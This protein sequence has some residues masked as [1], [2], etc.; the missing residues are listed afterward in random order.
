MMEIKRF[1]NS[2]Y[3]SNT[4]V[5]TVGGSAW[6]VDIGDIQPVADWL[7]QH[8]L[9]LK[10]VFLT[11]AHYDHIY[12]LNDLVKMY[13]DIGVY[14][15]SNGEKGLYSDK[16][17]MSR[18]AGTSFVYQYGNIEVL[19]NSEKVS[20]CDGYILT[21]YETPGHDWSCMCFLCDKYLFTGD[22]YLPQYDVFTGFPKSNK[23]EAQQSLRFIR[24]LL[25][26]RVNVC[27]PGHGEIVSSTVK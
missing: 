1:E 23:N 18:Y 8:K 6:L 3:Q 20:L 17:N 26:D 13:P 5:L 10:G 4:Y 19:K 7:R 27:C 12:G 9:D 21:A 25:C 24:Q 16:L 11:H 22:S 2:I 15:S 14:T